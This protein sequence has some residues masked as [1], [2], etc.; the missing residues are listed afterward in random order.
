MMFIINCSSWTY[1]GALD[2]LFIVIHCKSLIFLE[3][4]LVKVYETHRLILLSQITEVMTTEYIEKG[5]YSVAVN[6]KQK[7]P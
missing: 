2:L 4:S 7:Q 6:R 5:G 3:R 1:D